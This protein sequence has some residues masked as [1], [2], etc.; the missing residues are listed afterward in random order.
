[1][2]VVD[3]G[4]CV[5]MAAPQ[6]TAQYYAGIREFTPDG[7]GL[8][9][10]AADL[11][12]R[13]Y[14]MHGLLTSPEMQMRWLGGLIRAI[15]QDLAGIDYWPR[16]GARWRARDWQPPG[17]PCFVVPVR[18]DYR[19]EDSKERGRRATRC[20]AIVPAGLGALRVD[21]VL[22]PEVAT[23]GDARS[24]AYGAAMFDGMTITV[25]H[26]DDQF[27]VSGAPVTGADAIIAEQVAGAQ[28]YGCDALVWLELTVPEDRLEAIRRILGT[29]PLADARRVPLVLAGSWHLEVSGRWVNRAT[30]LRS[31]G[32]PLLHYD[33]RR[34]Y[35]FENRREAI[36]A[37]GVLPVIVME[38]RLVSLAICRDFCDDCAE[39]VYDELGIDLVLVPSMGRPTTMAAHD[40]SAKKLQ[41]QQGA[42]S[43][44]VQQV[45]VVTGEAPPDGEP[46]AYSFA[47]PAEH[48]GRVPVA[49]APPMEQSVSF[50]VLRARR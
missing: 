17:Y 27:R 4:R 22:H 41:S 39:D 46:P 50:R 20:H 8:R 9:D 49:S 29:E 32:R 3:L 23:R 16:R 37:G 30:V 34:Q 12:S 47:A 19:C 5:L 24:W 13:G 33:K 26:G 21:L 28:G 48:R 7:R 25:D 31:R 10:E 6:N 44:V 11:R 35:P 1:M 15:D 42:I 43:F 38:D 2:R 40:R 14:A 45:P 18:R 36:D